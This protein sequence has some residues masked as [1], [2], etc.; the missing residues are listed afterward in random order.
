MSFPFSKTERKSEMHFEGYLRLWTREGGVRNK[1]EK[2]SN[3]VMDTIYL[4]PFTVHLVYTN[5]K[6]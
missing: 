1:K 5:I 4:F 2:E 3:A 6:T